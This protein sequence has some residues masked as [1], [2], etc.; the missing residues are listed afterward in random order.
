MT[1]LESVFLVRRISHATVE[2]HSFRLAFYALES[3]IR[4]CAEA[5]YEYCGLVRQGIRGG[6]QRAQTSIVFGYEALGVDEFIYYASLGL[7]H[8]EQKRALELF[9]NEVMPAFA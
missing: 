1:S 4:D 6:L 7:G 8:A 3:R 5:V 2:S 9:C